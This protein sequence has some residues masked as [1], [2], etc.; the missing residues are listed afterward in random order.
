M[1]KSLADQLLE[2]GVVDKNRATKLKKAKHKQVKQRTHGGAS[3]DRGKAEARKANMEKVQRDR[4]LSQQRQAALAAKELAAQVRQL[5]E[6]N[7][8]EREADGSD[9]NFSDGGVVKKIPVTE[10][11][12]T[13]LINGQIAIVRL[14][15]AYFLVPGP[16][17]DKIQERDAASVL[18]K[19]SPHDTD[20]EIDED[21][22]D[23]QIPDDLTW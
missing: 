7:V 18:V 5:I 4:E 12:R 10:S 19:N 17:A 3:T 2:A 1:A 13:A 9:Y 11:Q 8:I 14:D 22:A 20:T 23:F 15:E 21:Y 16:V 6:R